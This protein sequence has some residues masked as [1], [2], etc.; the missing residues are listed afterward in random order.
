MYICVN[1]SVIRVAGIRICDKQDTIAYFSNSCLL[2]IYNLHSYWQSFQLHNP[3]TYGLTA[4][5]SSNN[6]TIDLY[7]EYWG[8]KL[9]VLK[10][11]VA[12]YKQIEVHTE[13]QFSLSCLP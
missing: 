5:Q 3:I 4:L 13:L 7:N 12:T 10:K 11:M 6:R 8:N 1:L 9:L 2:N